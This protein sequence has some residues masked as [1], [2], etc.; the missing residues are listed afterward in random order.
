MERHR[1]YDRY[2]LWLVTTLLKNDIY[3]GSNIEVER[4]GII[5]RHQLWL[6]ITPFLKSHTSLMFPE[7]CPDPKQAVLPST[8]PPNHQSNNWVGLQSDHHTPGSKRMHAT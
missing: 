6:D 5:V 2:R 4:K 1:I 7:H 8:L 3:N